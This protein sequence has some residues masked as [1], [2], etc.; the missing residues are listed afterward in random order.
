MCVWSVCVCGVCVCGFMCVV[1]VCGVVC[2]LCVCVCVCGLCVCVCGLCVCVCV[3]KLVVCC[4]T[5]DKLFLSKYIGNILKEKSSNNYLRR[6]FNM[7]FYF[8]NYITFI[9]L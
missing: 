3:C 6:S 1:C 9:T 7:F 8:S 4:G 5:K 2:G